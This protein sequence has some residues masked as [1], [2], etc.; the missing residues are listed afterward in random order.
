MAGDG[1][2]TIFTMWTLKR[3]SARFS[4]VSKWTSHSSIPSDCLRR[5]VK[6]ELL[7]RKVN[8]VK[9]TWLCF[10]SRLLQP[11]AQSPTAICLVYGCRMHHLDMVFPDVRRI[12]PPR[13]SVYEYVFVKIVSVTLFFAII[14]MATA[15]GWMRSYG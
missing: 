4:P 12:Q 9:N 10:T 14:L 11:V 6:P 5:G 13:A 8:V 3:L 1:A 15:V 2:R 7:R